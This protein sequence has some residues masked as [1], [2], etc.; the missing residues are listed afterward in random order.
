MW[1]ALKQTDIHLRWHNSSAHLF[2]G[3]TCR[4]WI[5]F[6][7]LQVKKRKEDY[8]SNLLQ[9]AGKNTKQRIFPYPSMLRTR[10]NR[11]SHTWRVIFSTFLGFC[12]LKSQWTQIRLI[13]L[14][15]F[16]QNCQNPLKLSSSDSSS[17]SPWKKDKS[18]QWNREGRS[19]LLTL[20]HF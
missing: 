11:E 14:K 17:S 4:S 12:C 1:R 13:A 15:N 18:Q 20:K 16:P 8:D 6:G 7:T 19:E 2:S 5:A 9:N 3:Q 10:R